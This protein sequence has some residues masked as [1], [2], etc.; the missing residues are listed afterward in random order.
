VL[1]GQPAGEL[2][3]RLGVEA[4]RAEAGEGVD[5]GAQLGLGEP[6]VVT[7][8]GREESAEAVPLGGHGE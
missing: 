3:L 5:P 6:R 1:G 4:D 2:L 8:G 7:A